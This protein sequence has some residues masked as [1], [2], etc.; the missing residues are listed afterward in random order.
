MNIKKIIFSPKSTYE[1]VLFVDVA[2]VCVCSCF[3]KLNMVF[4][5]NAAT[6]NKHF[7][8][9]N[10]Q[11]LYNCVLLALLGHH[12]VNTCNIWSPT[13]EGVR[14]F[15]E[16][17][18][19]HGL[20]YIAT[21]KR[22]VRVFWILVIIAGFTGAGVLIYQSFQNWSENPVTTTTETLPIKKVIFPKITV[23]PP[24][25]SYT[26][27]NP[28]LITVANKTFNM[29]NR[30]ELIEVLTNKY[31]EHFHKND[32]HQRLNAINAFKEKDKYSNWF[33]GVTKIPFFVDECSYCASEIFV[34]D[35]KIETY[36]TS[37]GIST[38]FFGETFDVDKFV[39]DETFRIV[40]YNPYNDQAYA[41]M[42]LSLKF[43]YDIEENGNSNLFIQC[44][45]GAVIYFENKNKQKSET[46][47]FYDHCSITY[48]RSNPK[49]YFEDLKTKRFTGFSVLWESSIGNANVLYNETKKKTFKE[50]STQLFQKL[51]RSML[52]NNDNYSE[53]DIMNIVTNTKIDEMFKKNRMRTT[54][55]YQSARNARRIF[56][57]VF[58]L[59]EVK[60][61][62]IITNPKYEHNKILDTAAEI[63]IYIMTPQV[64][65]WLEWYEIFFNQWLRTCSIERL[66]GININHYI[67]KSS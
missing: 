8:Y 47:N 5:F 26:D 12:L 32:F 56:E 55:I 67:S 42:N 34:E 11:F 21:T 44:D 17:S 33:N 10:K 29:D 66:L 13:M 38:P 53:I 18:T 35:T 1:C 63:F 57:N 24:K 25:N 28:D 62:N 15:L 6:I 49:L 58:N 4:N 3:Q 41:T 40:I 31:V 43:N 46:L 9:T 64:K 14:T 59:I 60:I 61:G 51:A 30:T 54:G 52:H 65:Y 48:Q 39:L 7:L 45:N 16:S 23:C 37:G 50:H 22:Y 19:V 36:A 20:A 2:V 27:L